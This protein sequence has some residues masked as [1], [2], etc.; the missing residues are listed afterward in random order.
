MY[1][2]ENITG[3]VPSIQ[4]PNKSMGRPLLLID[5][6]TLRLNYATAVRR[7]V[8]QTYTA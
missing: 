1:A 3:C 6:N 5:C 8:E 4:D 7:H 2:G